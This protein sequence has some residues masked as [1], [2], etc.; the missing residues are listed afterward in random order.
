MVSENVKDISLITGGI[1]LC[2]VGTAVTV[3]PYLLEGM[4]EVV[5]VAG[6][7][8]PFLGMG[9]I[10][11]ASAG[12][13]SLTVKGVENLY[14]HFKGLTPQ[15]SY[16]HENSDTNTQ[17]TGKLR[18][19]LKKEQ[20]LSDQDFVTAQRSSVTHRRPM[21][22]RFTRKSSVLKRMR[23]TLPPNNPKVQE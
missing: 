4:M 19:T 20:G 16:H 11:V 22:R 9:G 2:A 17:Q 3:N 5:R 13:A 1:A 14:H 18:V 15:R 12:L 7:V 8:G 23:R 10:V 6:S 21:T